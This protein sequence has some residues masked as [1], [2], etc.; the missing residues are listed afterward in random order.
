MRLVVQ[1]RLLI[2]CIMISLLPGC[3]HLVLPSIEIA[4]RNNVYSL[5]LHHD[6]LYGSTAEGEIFAFVPAQPES[7]STLTRQ[8]HIPLRAILFNQADELLALSFIGGLYRLKGDSLPSICSTAGWSLTAG[9][10]NWPWIAGNFGVYCPSND[11]ITTFV[12]LSYCHACA[13]SDDIVAIARLDG[14][15]LFDR[16][17]ATL[18]SRWLPEINFWTIKKQG[19][20]FVAGGSERCVFIDPVHG[21]VRE[22]TIGPAGNIVW[23]LVFDRSGTIYCATQHGLFSAAPDERNGRCIGFR[24]ECIKSLV[25]DANGKLWIGRFGS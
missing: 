12:R 22:I 7:A 2:P 11:S 1:L 19:A 17:T 25:F 3:N 23:D 4:P 10:G 13:V 14:L 6:S 15:D 18:R 21:V 24:G 16:H 9:G 5:I 20:L 8:P